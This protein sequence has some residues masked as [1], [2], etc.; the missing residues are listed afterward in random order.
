VR[1]KNSD[2]ELL[3]SIAEHRLLTVAQVSA[4]NQRSQRGIR[5]RL[6]ELEEAGTLR[7][8]V[9]GFGRE[10]G[11]PEKIV[12]LSEK[13][14]DLLREE[15]LLPREVP[16]ERVTAEAIRCVDH[17]MLVNWFRIHLVH[18]ERVI[19][20]LKVQFLSSTSPSVALDG[21]DRPWIT[22]RVPTSD[23][24]Q[25]S[26]AF[27]PDGVFSITDTERKKTLLFYL[28]VD[29]GTETIGSPQRDHR[30]VRQKILNYQALFRSGGYK[31]FGQMWTC[32]LIG[33]RLLFLAHSP[34]RFA[35]LC[36]LVHEMLPSDFIWLADQERLFAH[37]ASAP[38]WARGGSPDAPSQSI[39]GPSLSQPTPIPT[40][41]S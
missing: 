31:R 17:Q 10:R 36:R 4:L 11:R 15:G 32:P 34:G 39:L 37:G 6:Q 19:P 2:L 8:S 25:G 28:E 30:D 9:R 18:M 22:E 12:S 33:F 21:D 35:L 26:I 38:I 13:A 5:R 41:N 27:T 1:L 20:R 40:L 23:G 24:G 3:A 7:S 14:A 29:Q 16:L